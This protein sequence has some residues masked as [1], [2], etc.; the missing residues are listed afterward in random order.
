MRSPTVSATGQSGAAGP[1]P[2]CRRRQSRRA[3]ARERGWAQE[4]TAAQVQMAAGVGNGP[5][6]IQKSTAVVAAV[7]AVVVAVVAAVETREEQMTTRTNVQAT[8][9]E[10]RLRSSVHLRPEQRCRPW[11]SVLCSASAV[12]PRSLDGGDL[13]SSHD[14]RQLREDLER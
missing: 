8:P 3:E 9:R 4:V 5:N 2:I 6:R 1:V 12:A 7:V 11:V 10:I 13:P 14:E